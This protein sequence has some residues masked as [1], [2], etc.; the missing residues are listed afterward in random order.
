MLDRLT[1]LIISTNSS[2]RQKIVK[3]LENL[4]VHKDFVANPGDGL[5]KALDGNYDVMVIDTVSG[6]AEWTDYLTQI[7]RR[8]V[9]DYLVILSSKESDDSIL[10][11]MDGALYKKL[12]GPLEIKGMQLVVWGLTE[13]SKGSRLQ[14]MKS[15]NILHLEVFNEIAGKTLSSHDENKLLWELTDVIQ[16]KLNLYNVSIF[17][18]DPQ[19]DDIVL[20]A[21]S[22][23]FEEDLTVDY[24]LRKGEG[25]P[26]WVADNRRS[27]V[28]GDVKSG[29][30]SYSTANNV[31]SEMAVPIIYE[32]IIL[33]VLHAESVEP[34]AF[35]REDLMTFETVAEQM[36]MAFENLRLSKELRDTKKLT[37]IIND[38]LP[39][40]IIILDTDYSIEYANYTFC[41]IN[42]VKRED[43]LGKP[44]HE[45]VSD[46][47]LQKVDLFSELEKVLKFG[48]STSYT[49]I[50][51]TS[52]FHFD[53]I[54]NITI[55][56]ISAGIS[57][58]IMVLFQDVT[59]FSR[60]T[61]QL[62][63]LREISLAMERVEQRDKL[64]QLILSCVTAGFAMGFSRAFLFLVDDSREK[65]NGVMAVGPSSY[66]EAYR[67]W[68]ELSNQ[69]MSLEDYLEKINR[70]EMEVTPIQHLVE[71]LTFDM[72]DSRNVLIETVHS[73]KYIHILDAKDDTRIDNKMRTLLASDEIFTIP[74]IAGNEVIGVLLTDNAFSGRNISLESVEVLTMF[75]VSAAMAIEKAKILDMLEGKVAEL[76]KA[77]SEL[78]ETHKKMI[79]NERLAAIGEVSTRLAH[80]I[81]N[82]LST[83]GGFA[84]S[85]PKKYDDKSRTFRNASIIVEEVGRLEQLLTNVLD[86][87]KPTM[88][89]KKRTDIHELISN[90]LSIFE[91]AIDEK[92]ISV[93]RNHEC[94][95]L[96]ALFDPARI[97]QVLINVIHNAMNAMNEGGK[98]TIT[99]YSA[100]DEL[101][102]RVKD[103][104][105]GISE[106]NMNK[107]FEPF[108]TTHGKGTGLGL[109]ISRR[110]MQDHGGNITINSSIGKGTTVYITLPLT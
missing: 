19:K 110:I 102:I 40:S 27:L 31:R 37:D 83:I 20:K 26:G 59:E 55:S 2:M 106:D 5:R 30:E 13:S 49:N 48:L 6:D 1:Y 62:N 93:V 18:I 73:A 56:R 90:T 68:N 61:Y 7:G 29:S 54:L 8:G 63:L 103:T 96:F 39:V 109:S 32:D 64:L 82:P 101:D 45:H 57:P 25:M 70:G 100:E 79:R 23:G 34:E 52:P 78:E 81:R 65:L 85:I 11:T 44:F 51:H 89:E 99:T 107:I 69:Y 60:K 15:K 3:L 97:K 50:R 95:T 77:Y 47:L 86:F 4:T 91:S 67:I 76:E 71:G 43:V 41:E 74:L 53:K 88:P 66:E 72:N 108:Y 28:S 12:A 105:S 36:A 104:G 10:N 22:G 87:S 14:L 38:S 9:S 42:D 58:R 24:S 17:L 98:L 75:G 84:K 94:E 80:E 92:N 46:D 33:G 35:T 16:K 21:F